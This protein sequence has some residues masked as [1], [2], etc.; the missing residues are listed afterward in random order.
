VTSRVPSGLRP[1]RSEW[2]ALAACATLGSLLALPAPVTAHADIWATIAVYTREI[3]D[4]PY[5]YLERA[6]RAWT[7]LDHGST[8]QP[9]GEDIDTLLKSA[10]W[11]PAGLRLRAVHLYLQ[12]SLDAAKAQILKNLGT[13][14]D[15]TEQARILA[16]IELRLR[17]TAAALRAYRTGWKNYQEETDFISMLALERD[18]NIMPRQLLEEG[19]RVHPVSPGAY[20]AAFEVYWNAGG[21]ANLKKCHEL[22]RKASSVLWPRSTDWKLRHARVLVKLGRRKEAGAVALAA[23][24]LLDD[25]TRFKN[26]KE[27]AAQNRKELFALMQAS[28]K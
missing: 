4:N 8:M 13:A 21:P 23:L 10:K 17:D 25:D 1:S 24:E 15:G 6:E 16:R 22:S 7:I 12:D 11:R 27:D 2:A 19:I 5:A 28:R 26:E 14:A 9:A 3:E 18:R 20:L